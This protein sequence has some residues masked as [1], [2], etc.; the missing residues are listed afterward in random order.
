MPLKLVWRDGIAYVHG[1]IGGQRLRRSLKTSDRASAE[2]LCAETEARL[3]RES[4]YGAE[5]EATFANAALKYLAAGRP[6]RYVAA[7]IKALGKK[8]L[9]MIKPGD[10]KALSLELYPKAKASTR[11]VSVI[12]PCTAIINH[13]AELGMCHPIKC[14][15]FPEPRVL[16]HAVDRAWINAFMA[17]ATPRLGA[18]ALFMY[19]TGARLGEAVALEPKHLDL[20]GKRAILPRAKNSDPRIYYL[21]DEM[22]DVLRALPPRRTHG[23]RGPYRVFGYA[24]NTGPQTAWKRVCSRAQLPYRMPHEAGRHSFAT[25]ALIRRGIDPVTVAALGGWRNPTM[26]LQRYAHAENLG[27]VAETVFGRTGPPVAQPDFLVEKKL[28][29]IK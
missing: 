13:A 28:R 27:T 1:T 7:L 2:I 9:S 4:V 10:I 23:G 6:R 29:R 19:T 14:K 15:S 16:R 3:I 22:V 5:Y 18:L 17:R 26:L 21:T 20:D 25:E 11:N 8:R 24:K 12:R